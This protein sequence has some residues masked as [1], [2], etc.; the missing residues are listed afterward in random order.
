MSE[1]LFSGEDCLALLDGER[2]GWRRDREGWVTLE[3]SGIKWRVHYRRGELL[4]IGWWGM[5][6][7]AGSVRRRETFVERSGP[8]AI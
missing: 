1:L 6:E 5:P 8:P 2:S 4:E 3:R 7:G